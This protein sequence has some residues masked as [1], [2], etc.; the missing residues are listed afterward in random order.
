M[1]IGVGAHLQS[2]ADDVTDE[3]Q[4]GV[5]RCVRRAFERYVSLPVQ[6]KEKT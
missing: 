4:D 6:P 3:L 5:Q 2:F 1:V